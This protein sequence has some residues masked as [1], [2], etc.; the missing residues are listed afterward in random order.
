MKLPAYALL[1][2]SDQDRAEREARSIGSTRWLMAHAGDGSSGKIKLMRA[3]RPSF[4]YRGQN[5]HYDPCWPSIC[6]GFRDNSYLVRDLDSV[7]R[8]RLLRGLA[9]N[10][11]FVEE[12]SKHP[13]MKW[14]V[15]EHIVIDC[16]AIAQHY[17]VPTGYMDLSES[18]EVSAFFATCRYAPT[19][20][21]WEPMQDGEGVMYR[22]PVE[23]IDERAAPICYQPFPR[24]SRQ[25][26]WTV[27]LRLGEDFLQAPM[28]QAFRFDH[29]PKVGEG[30]LKRFGGGPDLP[31]PDPTARLAAAICAAKEIPIAYVEEAEAQLADDPSGV[32]SDEAKDIRSLLR[33]ELK[34]SF[35]NSSAIGYTSDEL[36]HA[37]NEWHK[38]RG[39]FYRGVGVRFVRTPRE[40]EV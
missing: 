33:N 10:I 8:A 16:A 38:L 14:A 22:L 34:Y 6:R 36:T 20:G 13:M 28:L 9:L 11:W 25:W 18:F 15:A 39:D 30:I 21:Q 19:R 12:V 37:E 23:A 27:E 24:P 3:D 1:Q 7:D 5:T 35:S 40:D 31:P 32:S 4:L 26:A 29:D 2:M 17:G